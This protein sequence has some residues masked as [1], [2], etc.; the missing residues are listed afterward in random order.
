MKEHRLY[1]GID[2]ARLAAAF[3][4]VAIHTAPL[5][6]WGELGDALVTYTLGRVAVP[7]FLMTTGY[8]VLGRDREGR[9]YRKTLLLYLL[10]TLLYLPLNVYAGNLPRTLGGAVQAVVLDGTFYHL[11]YL[12]AA[13]LG[14]FLASGWQ[15]W[16]SRRAA[17]GISLVLYGLGV[18]GD[19]WF[20]LACRFPP[21]AA[22]YSQLFRFMRYTRN[23]IFLAPIFLLLGAWMA[24]R[25]RRSKGLLWAGLLVSL[26]LLT[27][28]GYLTYSRLWQ[29]HSSM[30]FSLLPVMVCL[31]ALLRQWEVP[32]P[33]VLRP[34][35]QWIYILHPLAIVGVRGAAKILRL[36]PLLVG[37]S[38][39]HYLA[40]CAVS[41]AAAWAIAMLTARRS[42]G[43]PSPS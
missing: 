19:S 17:I 20:Y 3:L 7:F 13:V 25:P 2:W 39:V 27:G 28:E 32:A 14:L 21:L 38:L 33:A 41:A 29:R 23:G 36:T 6:S 42:A 35:S 8:F 43:K 37:N 11:W 5:S 4:I 24:G 40:V 30:Y 10:A 9:F 18:L 34:M 31:F 16:W 12:P 15:G 22:L 26:A 1:G